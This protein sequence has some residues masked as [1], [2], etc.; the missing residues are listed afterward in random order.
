MG[1]ASEGYL[2][3]ANYEALASALADLEARLRAAPEDLPFVPDAPTLKAGDH[4]TFVTRA[5]NL[6]CL[7]TP[8]GSGG[9]EALRRTAREMDVGG[10]V[11]PVGAL[12]DLIAMKLAAGRPKDRIEVEILRAL[13]EEIDAG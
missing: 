8:G 4:F 1:D 7:G 6:D 11:V 12:P 10:V 3:P 2:L 13:E 5:G 9:F